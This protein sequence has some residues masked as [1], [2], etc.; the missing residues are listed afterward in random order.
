VRYYRL[1]TIFLVGN[2]IA[3]ELVAIDDQRNGWRYLVL[4][5]ARSDRLVMRCAL[6]AAAF[7]FTTNVSKDLVCPATIYQSAIAELQHRKDIRSY[8]NQDQQIIMLSLLTLLATSMV[9]GSVDFRVIL[10]MIE[11]AWNAA[12][13]EAS[14]RSGELGVFITRQYRK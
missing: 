5:I 6:A 4:P 12:G 10:H 11:A 14:F 1:L 2:E 7:H 13:G 3:S 8:C 9:S